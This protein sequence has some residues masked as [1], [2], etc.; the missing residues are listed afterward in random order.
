[1]NAF[2]YMIHSCVMQHL[3]E[4]S[5]IAVDGGDYLMIGDYFFS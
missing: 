2:R 1:M 4:K 3:F 5:S